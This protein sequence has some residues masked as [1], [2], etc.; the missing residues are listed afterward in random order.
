MATL[1]EALDRVTASG[2]RLDSLIEYNKG[3]KAQL[4][5]VLAGVLTPEQQAQIDAIFAEADENVGKTDR[6]LNVNVPPATPVDTPADP[7]PAI[8]TPPA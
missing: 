5:S 1:Q 3:I 2:D 6:A 4:D 7:S 8:E